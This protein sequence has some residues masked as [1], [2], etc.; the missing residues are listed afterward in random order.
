MPNFLRLENATFMNLQYKDF[1]IPLERLQNDLGTKVHNFDVLNHFDDLLEVLALRASVDLLVS[2]EITL[3]FIFA[4]LGTS[5][6]LA[7]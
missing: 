2:T 3:P 1:E 4:S 7:N 6:S 5:T